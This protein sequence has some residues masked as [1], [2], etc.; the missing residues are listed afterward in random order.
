MVLHYVKLTNPTVISNQIS[1]SVATFI[2]KL[3]IIPIYEQSK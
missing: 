3:N 2:L 1:K